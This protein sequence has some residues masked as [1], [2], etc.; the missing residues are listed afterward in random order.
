MD[1]V[2]RHRHAQPAAGSV[3]GRRTA[4][5]PEHQVGQR[6]RRRTE[7]GS[8]SHVLQSGPAGPLLLTTDHERLDSE[9]PPDDQGTDAGW[10][11]HL[12]GRH[13]HEVGAEAH[14]GRAARGR[15]RPRRR[16]GR[17]APAARHRSTTSA[18]GWVVPTSWLAHWQW[19]TDGPRPYSA[20]HRS[21]A[22]S[23]AAGSMRPSPSTAMVSVGAE[24]IEA[25][26]TAECSTLA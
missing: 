22:S 14:R 20:R 26:R 10:A 8:P 13:R 12:V 16:R 23:T 4:L 9:P 17:A 19:T 3:C 21:R 6:R 18:T 5:S 24:R 2:H 11:A 15:P 1:P 7:P 25:S